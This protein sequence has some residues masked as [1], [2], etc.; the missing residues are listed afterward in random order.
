[1]KNKL[2]LFIYRASQVSYL[3]VF[4]KNRAYYIQKSHTQLRYPIT[5]LVFIGF[6]SIVVGCASFPEVDSTPAKEIKPLTTERHKN[7]NAIKKQIKAGRAEENIKL[8]L[9]ERANYKGTDFEP[10][11]ELLLA[12]EY[13][14]VQRH[15]DAGLAFL[16]AARSSEKEETRF[17][18][19]QM[20]A[21]SFQQEKD[22]DRYRRGMDFCLT[23]FELQPNNA[24][25]IRSLKIQAMEFSG[26]NPLEVAKS[27]V[28]LSAQSQ[29][30][31]ESKNRTKALQ[32]IETMNASDLESLTN[33][34]NFGFLR[35]HAAYRLGQFYLAQRNN[36]SAKRAFQKVLQFLPETEL[37]ETAQ[38]RIDQIDLVNHV[39]PSTL[40][41]VLPLSGKHASLGQKLLRG[42]QMGIGLDG[43][44]AGNPIKLAVVDSEG[45][46]DTA[47]KGV[48]KLVHEDSVIAV[49]GSLLSK[50][51]NAV[52]DQAQ[53]L[54]VPNL[55]LSQ[56]SGLTSTGDNIFRFGMTSEMQVRY[57]VK[58]CMQD[59]GMRRF[60]I[61]YP[62]DKFGVEY[63]N[64][65]WD[66]VRAR[67]G[68]IRAAQTYDADETDFS[69]LVQRLTGTF[70]LE[71]RQ[72][73]LRWMEKLQKD[74]K[75]KVGSHRN[76]NDEKSLA[77]VV[78]FDAVFIADGIK[79]MGQISAMLAFNGVKGVRIIG[80]NLWNNESI[81]K[82]VA[83]AGNQIIFVDGAP[84][85]GKSTTAQLFI[86]KYKSYF[87]ENPGTFEVQGYEAGL[88]LSKALSQA[89]SSRE[90]F[91]E[92]LKSLSSVQGL[93]DMIIKGDDREFIKPLYLYTIE[94]NQIKVME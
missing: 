11:L 20:A 38:K 64:L 78:D 18:L 80:P 55:A 10:D 28:E 57:L 40:G 73:E 68:E 67:G 26:V 88:L 69:G 84:F 79:A 59:L 43:E 63:A 71:D 21:K 4:I 56:K 66:E 65:F 16:R 87:N 85:S 36:A 7:I 37:A 53:V 75:Q 61:V 58:R 48:E 49:V 15:S 91:K 51:A 22:W 76:H 70:F 32:L 33:D 35:G 93:T 41:V 54:N 74:E 3:R 90:D 27:Y 60:A 6:V 92:R 42:L 8:I 29:G 25:Q 86:K 82:R 19:C 89:V 24:N 17:K 13:I 12:Q 83:N 46:P 14:K 23:H 44:V 47:R 77:P 9:G 81:I 34:S 50:T 5:S 94:G 30:E 39:N 72:E 2:N 31:A 1:M 62:N 45:N 52:A